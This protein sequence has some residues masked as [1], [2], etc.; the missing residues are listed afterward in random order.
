[1]DRSPGAAFNEICS[2]AAPDTHK[3]LHP[4]QRESAASSFKP[5][6]ALYM[7]VLVAL[8]LPFQF[9]WSLSQLNLSTFA[10]QSDCDARPVADG[11]CLM[12][13][14]HTKAE[15]TYVVNA[16]IVGG[17]IGS[18]SCGSLA[19]KYGRRKV[20]MAS[21]L[22]MIVGGAIQASTSS[23]SV[24]I[25]GRVIAGVSSGTAT[26]LVGGYVNEIAPPSLRK[27]LS[28][29]L[30][31]SV[32]TGT[33]LVVCTFF[34]ANTSSGWRYIAGF[35]ITYG[36]TF[37]LLASFFLVESPAWLLTKGF[38]D[39]AARVM[40]RIYGEE[41]VDVAL[42][43]FLPPASAS[44]IE[45]PP[46]GSDEDELERSHP[47]N[48]IALLLSPLFRRQLV[49][50]IGLASAQQLSGISGVFYYSSS[51]FQDAGI[52]DDRIGSVVVNVMNFLPTF[53]TAYAVARY[54]YRKI[55]L[56]GFLGMFASAIGITI[57]FLVNVAALSIVFTGTYVAFFAM[58]VG[59][60]MYVVVAD[61]FPDSV[62]ATAV[63]F[64]IFSNW[65][66]NLIVGV[67]FPYMA[68]ALEDFSF[69]PFIVLLGCF[70]VFT[71]RM[72][73]ETSGKTNE[74]TQAYFRA[75]R[76]H[77]SVSRHS[78]SILILWDDIEGK[79]NGKT[80][81]TAQIEFRAPNLQMDS[82]AHHWVPPQDSEGASQID[83]E[84]DQ[85]GD[86]T[87]SYPHTV[88]KKNEFH[89]LGWVELDGDGDEI[90]RREC[91]KRVRGGEFGFCEILNTTSG[92]VFR[93]MQTTHLSLKDEVRFTCQLAKEF[94]N[95]RHLARTYRHDPPISL[96]QNAESST[97]GI[98][99][100]VYERVLPSA[101]ASIRL[102]RFKGC[103]L[104]I[105][106]W[107]R[108]D[109]L[110]SDNPVLQELLHAFG[111]IQL[112]KIY[113]ERIEG[114]MSKPTRSIT[115]IFPTC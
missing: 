39:E 103:R 83:S 115:R 45:T 65:L 7:S 41:H 27:T 6:W 62:R 92:K 95:F 70:Y 49:A 55:I 79:S 61:L 8:M 14:G 56:F 22:F 113:D 64:C 106:L 46:E 68:D 57:A 5:T 30:Q 48:T 32:S 10:S 77:K 43:W 73:P 52:D 89:C 76:E 88:W 114:F 59:P 2:P 18:L 38:H 90:N 67:S 104:P 40:A 107:F 54:G 105:E 53:T 72:I 51:F 87:F 71:F 91:W 37:L 31:I 97:N 28:A 4:I 1:M 81:I 25:V 86:E 60:L 20:L 29:G 42:T 80:P 35:P 63:S 16:W 74:E 19:D 58:S 3:S 102:L 24:F 12:F 96:D 93:V 82:W 75:L 78:A 100:T 9:G 23:I 112:R 101:Y 15:W 21:S 110:S 33:L 85:D 69:L 13:P 94:T 50:A 34:F 108:H 26:G 98:A 44:D 11:T 47:Q 111:P 17:M 99:M 66:S 84:D 109:E 36:A